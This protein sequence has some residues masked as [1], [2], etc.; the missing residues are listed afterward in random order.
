MKLNALAF[1][2]TFAILDL[3]FHPLFHAWVFLAPESYQWV[4]NLFVAGLQLQVTDFDSKLSH[5]A[6]GTVLEAAVFWMLGFLIA[7]LYNKLS[8]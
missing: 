1:A 7:T 5:I 2:N 4:M 8:K 3:I 6:I